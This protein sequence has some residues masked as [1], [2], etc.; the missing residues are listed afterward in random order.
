MNDPEMAGISGFFI[1]T[2]NFIGLYDFYT[3]G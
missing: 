1:Y 2:V 3:E